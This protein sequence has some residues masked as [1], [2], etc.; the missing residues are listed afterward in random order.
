MLKLFALVIL[1]L[2][3]ISACGKTTTVVRDAPRPPLPDIPYEKPKDPIPPVGN[4]TDEILQ[5]DEVEAVALSD[6][7]SLSPADAQNTVYIS[8]ADTFN[9]QDDLK[10]ALRGTNLGFNLLSNRTSM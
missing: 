4:P 3:L 7:F 6:A 5:N 10:T 9:F 2:M 8:A 1:P